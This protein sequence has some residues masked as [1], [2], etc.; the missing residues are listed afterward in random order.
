MVTSGVAF[1]GALFLIEMTRSGDRPLVLMPHDVGENIF[2]SEIARGYM[3]F[4]GVLGHEFVGTAVRGSD[5][6]AGQRVVAEINCVP[7]ASPALGRT[8]ARL[9]S[10]PPAFSQVQG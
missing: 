6:L 1:H 5:V 10:R 4:A 8:Q 9:G 7:P 2:V 3:K